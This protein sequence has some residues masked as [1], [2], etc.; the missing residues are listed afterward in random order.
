[1]TRWC[2]VLG[3]SIL[4]GAC[5]G[6]TP[7]PSV[8]TTETA[9]LDPAGDEDWDGLSNGDEV[10]VYGTDPLRAD[11]DLDRLTDGSEIQEHGTDPLD[12]DSDADSLWDGAEVDLGT[13]PTAVDT[14]GDGLSDPVEVHDVPSDPTLPDTDSDGLGDGDE[15]LIHGTDPSLPDTD[16]DGLGDGDE[17][18]VHGTDPLSADTDGD[19]LNDRDELDVHG[20]DPIQQDTDDGGVADGIEIHLGTLPG[21]PT[22]D[23]HGPVTLRDDFEEGALKGVVWKGSSGELTVDTQRARSGVYSMVMGDHAAVETVAFDA[24]SCPLV[25]W[26][27]QAQRGAATTIPF[28]RDHLEVSYRSNVYR[29]LLRLPDEDNPYGE[30]DA[31]F[32]RHFGVVTDKSALDADLQLKLSIEGSGDDDVVFVDDFRMVCSGDDKDGDG[33]PPGL[34]CDP[35]T[36]AHWFDCGVCEDADGDGY[37]AGCD[38]GPDCN[39][40][41]SDAHP[42]VTDVLGD[43]VDLDCDGAD[44]TALLSDDFER[45]QLASFDWPIAQDSALLDSTIHPP[46]G[47]QSVEFDA[48]GLLQSDV[49]DA[50]ACNQ[51]LFSFEV[52]HGR[53][54]AGAPR[55]LVEWVV[56]YDTGSGEFVPVHTEVGRTALTAFELRVVAMPADAAS[57]TLTLRLEHM[58]NSVHNFFYVDDF[59][60]GCTNVDGDGDGFPSAADCDDDD[61]DLWASCGRCVDAD[62]DGFG[63]GCDRGADCD[64]NAA[65]V[66][67]GAVDAVGDGIDADCSGADGPGYRDGFELGQAD[68]LVWDAADLVGS[69]AVTPDRGASEGAHALTLAGTLGGITASATTRPLDTSSCAEVAYALDVNVDESDVSSFRPVVVEAWS[70]TEWVV[71]EE[72]SK[73]SGFVRH[74]GLGS[75]LGLRHDAFR[76]RVR[77]EAFIS[78]ADVAVV[79]DIVVGCAGPDADGDGFPQLVDCDDGDGTRWSDCSI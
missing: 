69:W 13:D 64:D 60:L 72:I 1:M 57:S 50:S 6:P 62:A 67:P 66:H 78:F 68:T 33:V 29:E 71:L 51:V 76:L 11:T 16:A 26:S 63:D 25:A 24:T 52:K 20:T 19:R 55:S 8:S 48:G 49:I 36:E 21:D 14:D 32:V 31:G 44:G 39:D 53:P 56:S 77:N 58:A 59:V 75:D 23:D 38:L 22:D 37:G 34:D 12:R 43:G 54:T 79:D 45:S 73:G 46:S 17:L 47:V 40:A 30:L 28:L 74:A 7:T 15:V 4:L 65:T 27:F 18:S 10:D 9:A 70:G 42:G 41:D 61:A 3:G 2:A 5:G 35:T